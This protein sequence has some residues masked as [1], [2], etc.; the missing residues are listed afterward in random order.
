M[1][2]ELELIW[3]VAAPIRAQPQQ[4]SSRQRTS[5]DQVDHTSRMKQIHF[6]HFESVG[7]FIYIAACSLGK[8]RFVSGTGSTQRPD[9]KSHLVVGPV[10]SGIVLGKPRSVEGPRIGE[11]FNGGLS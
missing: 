8:T 4:H 2:C 1:S 10:L 9:T 6:I 7:G 5:C 11:V 3:H